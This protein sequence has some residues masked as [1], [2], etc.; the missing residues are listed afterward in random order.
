MERFILKDPALAKRITLIIIP[1]LISGIFVI[2]YFLLRERESLLTDPYK[3]VA[4]GACIIIETADFKS[5][6]NSVTTGKGLPGEAAKVKGWENFSRKLKYL[7]DQINKAEFKKLMNEAAVISFHP[8]KEENLLTLLSIAIPSETR[9]KHLKEILQSSGIK[10]II[11]TKSAGNYILKIPF[12]I[13]NIRDTAYISIVSGLLLCSNSEYMIEEAL[14]QTKKNT[15]VRDLKGFSRVYLASGKN[16]DKIF[17]VFANLGKIFDSFLIKDAA[18]VAGHISQLAVTAGGDIFLSEDGVVLSGYTESI[19]TSEI[20]YKY[21]FLP[22]RPFHSYK[23]LPASTVLFETMILPV[24]KVKAPDEDNAVNRIKELFGEEITRAVMDIKNKSLD[25]N[26]LFIYEL[27]NSSEAERIFI[28][29]PDMDKEILF[30]TPDDQVRIPVYHTILNGFNTYHNSGNQTP[31]ENFYFAFY[32]NFLI[33]GKSYEA[34]S[35]LLNDNLLNRTLANDLT[36]R[37]FESTLPTQGCYFFYC[38]PSKITDYLDGYFNE[39]LNLALKSNKISLNRIQSA[40]WSF[41]SRNGMIYNSLSIKFKEQVIQEST[42]EWET[43]LD[44]VAGIKPFFFTN[45][46]TGVKEIFLQDLNNNIYLINSSGRVLWKVSLGEKI[47]GQIYQIDYFRNGKY[48]LLFAGRNYIHLFDRNGNYVERYPVKLRSPASGPLALFDYDK[49]LDYRLFI[50]GDDKLIYSYD[51][52]GNV[53]KGWKPFRTSGTV[54]AEIKHFRTSG[55]DYIVACDESSF[56]FLDR[57]GNKRINV[58]QTVTKAPGSAV[59]LSAGSN[60]SVV[61]SSTDGTIMHIYFDGSIKKDKI[62]EFSCNHWFDI[63]DIDGDGFGEY[64]FIDGNMIYLYDRSNT[65][66]F[67]RKFESAVLSEPMDFIFSASDRK[68]GIFDIKNNLIYLINKDGETMN[69][70]PLRGAS[71][72]SVNKLLEN[73]SWNLLVGGADRFLYN[74]KI[75]LQLK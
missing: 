52:S 18:E 65:E 11:E 70:F 61:C 1:I 45:H 54:K 47:E 22:S 55:K 16:E 29:I 6:L 23:I 20:L 60:P 9:P 64:I 56:Y 19:D 13:N 58:R 75:E 25:E 62:R 5:F 14:S 42:T 39:D 57:T 71:M 3:A 74:Y 40:G 15:D 17:V 50:A 8:G 49:N 66:L 33:S 41:T 51:K 72:F 46:I 53:V 35:V 69:G 48:Q 43:L 34:V 36:F 12:A 68:F 27:T 30:F 10:Q 26:N 38:I 2:G 24:K 21:K 4:P 37:D 67:S 73:S 59:R 28:E 7:A 32:D 44:T 31:N 63:F